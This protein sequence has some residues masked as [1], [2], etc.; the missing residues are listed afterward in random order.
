MFSVTI[1]T[2][3]QYQCNIHSHLLCG[4]FLITIT[5]ADSNT[6]MIMTT[7]PISAMTTIIAC[8]KG[9]GRD[10][11]QGYNTCLVETYCAHDVDVLGIC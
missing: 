9:R 1:S 10:G 5:A 11:H 8:S 4:L 2:L 3:L 7:T 6:A